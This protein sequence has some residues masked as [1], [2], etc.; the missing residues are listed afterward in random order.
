[1]RF[2]ITLDLLTVCRAVVMLVPS[3]AAAY[4]TGEMVWTVPTLAAAGV[5]AAN[6][7]PTDPRTSRRVDSDDG[8]DTDHD[9]E[10]DVE[11][12]VESDVDTD[13][14]SDVDTDVESDVDTE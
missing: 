12:D 6:L 7:K 11:T 8:D 9:V 4:L 5:L 13:V 3:Y 1:M 14:E 10:T 2:P